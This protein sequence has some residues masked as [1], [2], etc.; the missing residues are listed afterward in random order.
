MQFLSYL[1]FLLVIPGHII[2]IIIIITIIVI[3]QPFL[4]CAEPL[5]LDTK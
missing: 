1:K 2:I 5:A 4:F 3:P